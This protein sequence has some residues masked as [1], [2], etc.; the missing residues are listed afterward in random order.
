MKFFKPEDFKYD[1]FVFGETNYINIEYASNRANEK[2]EREARVVYGV[3]ESTFNYLVT[4]EALGFGTSP[5]KLS[6]HKALLINIEPIE[7][8]KHPKEKVCIKRNLVSH[9]SWYECSCGV[10]VEPTT[11]GVK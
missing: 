10:E 9:T 1:S 8:C 6:T 7:D 2:L 11:Y 3:I 5:L 4:K